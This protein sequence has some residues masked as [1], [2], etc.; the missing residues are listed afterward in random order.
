MPHALPVEGTQHSWDRF[1]QWTKGVFP[2]HQHHAQDINWG[3]LPSRV[4]DLGS[5]SGS[6]KGS[7]ALHCTPLHCFV[8]IFFLFITIIIFIYY[9]CG[10]ALYFQL[11][12]CSYVNIETLLQLFSF[13]QDVGEERMGLS[14]WLCA[15]SSPAR[16]KTTIEAKNIS[17]HSRTVL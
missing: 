6:G 4:G 13:H 3:N 1:L 2:H 11:L 17:S 7:I 12:N 16:L 10:I 9:Y 15:V 14:N 8:R 5:G